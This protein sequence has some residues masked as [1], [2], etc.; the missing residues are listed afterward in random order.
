[1]T[2]K[3]PATMFAI[4][5]LL[6]LAGVLPASARGSAPSEDP[7]SPAHIEG[8]PRKFAPTLSARPV[9]VAHQSRPCI[10]SPGTYKIALQGIG[11]SRSISRMCTVL[12]EQP[13]ARRR[14]ACIKCMCPKAGHIETLLM[15]TRQR[16]SSS[17]WTGQPSLKLLAANRLE[18]A[19]GIFA[20]TAP[21]FDHW[22]NRAELR[23]AT[24]KP[25]DA[26]CMSPCG[27]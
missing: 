10:S 19:S 18:R 21:I 16:L 17:F 5:S 7:L 4:V 27:A 25:R 3:L 24:R 23:T 1:M 11:S 26:A 2:W 20:G 6:G 22:S 15:S 8:L 13:Y 14:G 12:I 9:L